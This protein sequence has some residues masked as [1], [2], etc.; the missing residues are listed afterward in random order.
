MKELPRIDLVLLSSERRVLFTEAIIND[1]PVI[2]S[3]FKGRYISN[4]IIEFDKNKKL[5]LKK[6]SKEHMS[7]RYSAIALKDNYED[8]QDIK[9]KIERFKESQA[10]KIKLWEKMKAAP[11][12]IPTD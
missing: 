6:A 2:N 7:Y 12:T 11:E 4:F 5:P 1:T 10:K 9:K 8:D 3:G